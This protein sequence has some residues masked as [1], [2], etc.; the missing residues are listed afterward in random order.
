MKL[1]IKDWII[2][3]LI[4]FSIFFAYKWL[5]DGDKFLKKENERLETQITKVQSERDSIKNIIENLEKDFKLIES[6]IHVKEMLVDSLNGEILKTK[7]DLTKSKKDLEKEKQ[8]LIEINRKI[9]ELKSIPVKR[10]GNDLLESIKQ[11]T[12]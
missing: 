12:K 10:T 2:I 8:K 5:I 6:K 9:K 11:K 4:G 3:I 1:E 7:T